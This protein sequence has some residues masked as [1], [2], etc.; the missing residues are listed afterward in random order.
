MNVHHTSRTCPLVKI[1]DILRDDVQFPACP[2]QMR[3]QS[4]EGMM[5]GIGLDV[6]KHTATQ[7]VKIVNQVRISVEG[8]RCCQS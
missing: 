7:I 3:S 6:L 1:V 5:S 8:L 2:G 4:D